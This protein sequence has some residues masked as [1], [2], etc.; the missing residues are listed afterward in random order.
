MADTEATMIGGFFDTE[1]TPGRVVTPN[2][3]RFKRSCGMV[4]TAANA[5]AKTRRSM[6]TPA[7]ASRC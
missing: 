5:T 6:S 7:K 2:G 1:E 3:E 4:L